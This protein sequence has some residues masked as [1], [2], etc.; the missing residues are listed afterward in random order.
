M[1]VFNRL[2]TL[3]YQMILLLKDKKKKIEMK[4]T[5]TREST[6]REVMTFLGENWI[7]KRYFSALSI[8]IKKVFGRESNRSVYD[9]VTPEVEILD[10]WIL[11]GKHA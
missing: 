7:L 3:Q 9:T 2:V 1:Y 6:E 10:S 11:N 4:E 8:Y 5:A